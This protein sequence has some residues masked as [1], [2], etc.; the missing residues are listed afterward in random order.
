VIFGVAV[1]TNSKN[2][3][4]IFGEKTHLFGEPCHER[5]VR[6]LEEKAAALT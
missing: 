5:A 6:A 3:V 4:Q 1:Y 2:P